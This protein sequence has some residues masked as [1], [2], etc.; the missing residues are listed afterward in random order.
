MKKI[1][2]AALASAIFLMIF[3]V[4]GCFIL[5]VHPLYFEENEDIEFYTPTGKIELYSS[6]LDEL[7]FDPI[8][9]YEKHEEP[10]DGFYRLLYGRAPMHTFGRTT[11]NPLLV[12]LKE[13]NEVWI[14]KKV[15]R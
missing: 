1:K 8:P 2:Y 12:D 9:V 3:F 4:G 5:S 11:N 15:A 14:N 13:D 7:D 6:Q 10:P